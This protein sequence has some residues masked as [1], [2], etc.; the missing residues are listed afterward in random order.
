MLAAERAAVCPMR[1]RTEGAIFLKVLV[2]PSPV[3]KITEAC[4]LP[5]AEGEPAV[6]ELCWIRG[7]P[8]TQSDPPP[9]KSLRGSRGQACAARV[10]HWWAP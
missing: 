7:K 10:G 4:Q 2:L 1:S 5:G 9:P 6:R 8:S 3:W